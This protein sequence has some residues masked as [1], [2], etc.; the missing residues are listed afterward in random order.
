MIAMLVGLFVRLC[1]T[2]VTLALRLT[3]ALTT[4]VLRLLAFVLARFWHSWRQRPAGPSDAAQDKA[5]RKPHPPLATPA[6]PAGSSSETPSFTPRPLR[7]RPG[8]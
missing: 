2:L 3:I 7:R 6:V 8:R 5:A 4:L 1:L